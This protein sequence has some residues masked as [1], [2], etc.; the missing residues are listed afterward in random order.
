MGKSE[1]ISSLFSR[2]GAPLLLSIGGH[3]LTYRKE[4]TLCLHLR[5]FPERTLGHIMREKKQNECL[6][7]WY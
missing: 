3:S 7:E 4:T 6:Q 1:G 2:R 5:S